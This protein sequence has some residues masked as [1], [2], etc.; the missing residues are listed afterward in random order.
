MTPTPQRAAISAGVG[1]CLGGGSATV[2]ADNDA[3][4]HQLALEEEEPIY[5]S[6]GEVGKRQANVTRIRKGF[7]AEGFKPLTIFDLADF[8][9]GKKKLPSQG[10]LPDKHQS[11]R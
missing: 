10:H 3:H 5:C 6:R 11:P 2:F 8:P 1:A 9:D 4:A 7:D